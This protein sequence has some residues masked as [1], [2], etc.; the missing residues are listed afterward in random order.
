MSII[1]E[2]HHKPFFSVLSWIVTVTCTI[3]KL[4]GGAPEGA[5]NPLHKTQN[6]N[7]YH[8]P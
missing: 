1:C 7:Q 5:M 2:T 3:E 4:K 6:R 8:C